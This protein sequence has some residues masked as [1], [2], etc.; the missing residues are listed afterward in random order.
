[1]FENRFVRIGLSVF[2]ALF[3]FHQIYSAL[4][5]PIS[6]QSA[7]FFTE[8]EGIGFTGMIIRN[9]TPVQR[10][11]GGVMHL[12]VGDGE[13]VAK[14]GTV[15]DIYTSEQDSISVNKISELKEKI[16]NIEQ[17]QGYNDLAAVDINLLNSKIDNTLGEILYSCGSRNFKKAREQSDTLLTMMNR[18]EMVVG[19]TGDFSE[20]LNTF[21]NELSQLEA[22]LSEPINKITAEES[23]FFISQVDGYESVL[24]TDDL[25]KYTPEF[26]DSVE[27]ENSNTGDSIGKIVSDYK[28]YIA[29]TV[30]VDQSL[31]YKAGD[32]VKIKTL[33]KSN[34]YINVVV[35][36]VNLSADR[37]RAVI[38]FSCQE[39]NSELAT[40]RSGSMTIISGEYE[41]LRIERGAL[42]VNDGQTGV[43]IVSGMELK[44]VKVK[45]LYQSEDY[46]ICEKAVADDNKSLRLHDKVV[47]K[48]RNLYEGKIVD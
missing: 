44:F 30:T 8:T 45:V 10:S 17:I 9:E 11:K 47:V 6:T 2:I 29:A 26:I 20:Q 23:G 35:E 46:I 32:N 3:L 34:P 1:M 5:T 48:G 33:L 31:P 38:I 28:W 43:Y 36:A 25:E 27:P 12:R 37:Q 40:M 18:R 42:R 41:G 19:N 22:S 14:D 24:T 13:R 39:M 21:K 16:N 4:Y 7:Q 15:A